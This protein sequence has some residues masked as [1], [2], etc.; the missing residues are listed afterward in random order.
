MTAGET[1][2]EEMATAYEPGAHEAAIYER[3]ERGGYFRP[4]GEG[5]PF[6]I[7]MPP[8][9][10]TGELHVGSALFV[11][12]EDVLI[13]W[14]RMLGHDTLWQPGVDHAAIAVNGIVS[15]QLREEGV[16]RLEIGR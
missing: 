14:H 2:G 8:P 15:R 11:T 13:R 1:T 5:E 16:D 7:I 10:L 4:S 9:N 12:L 6:T 3:W